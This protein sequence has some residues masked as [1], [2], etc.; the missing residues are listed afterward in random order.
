MS[1]LETFVLPC[2]KHTRY[3]CLLNGTKPSAQSRWHFISVLEAQASKF[4]TF[5]MYRTRKSPK[6][7]LRSGRPQSERILESLFLVDEAI[8]TVWRQSRGKI[9]LKTLEL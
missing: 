2:L 7:R 9:Y 8:T 6:I 4:S 1:Q 5:L 3:A